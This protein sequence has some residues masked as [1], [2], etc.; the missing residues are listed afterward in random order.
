MEAMKTAALLNVTAI[1]QPSLQQVWS[2]VCSVGTALRIDGRIL[3]VTVANE[4][5]AKIIESLNLYRLQNLVK[6]HKAG[7]HVVR[8]APKLAVAA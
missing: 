7:Y 4:Y 3:L 1:N 5:E 8:V 6:L 2:S